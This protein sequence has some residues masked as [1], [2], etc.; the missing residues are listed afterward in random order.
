MNVNKIIKELNEK[1]PGKDIFKNDGENNL[2]YRQGVY[3]FILNHSDDSVL[4]VLKK[5]SGVWDFP[6]GGVDT[7]ENAEQAV[8][9]ELLE[10]LGTDKFEILHKSSN[11]YKYDWPL[12]EIEKNI[13][14]SGKLMRGQEQSF[15]VLR[16]IGTET[17]IVLQDL[18][19]AESRWV[20]LSEIKD[21]IAYPDFYE[22]IQKVFGEIGISL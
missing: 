4:M 5:N 14:K 6:G 16:F 21:S 11:T 9:R 15:F 1:Y 3:A 2:P 8:N 13:K 18:E 19:L 20:K 22:H 7:G 10:E 17:D 12:K